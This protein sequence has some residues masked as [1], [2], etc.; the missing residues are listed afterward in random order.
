M[1]TV[2]DHRSTEAQIQKIL[3]DITRREFIVGG[4]AL[5][6]LL[7]GCA[8]DDSDELGDSPST[9]GPW[10]FTDDR[11]V[12][13]TL[14]TMP[15]RIAMFSEAAGALWEYGI[16]PVGVFGY[17]PM[18]AE[19]ALAK[20]DLTG[21]VELG[22][23][24]GEIPLEPLAALDADLIVTIVNSLH[25]N[26]PATPDTG[27]HTFSGTQ[28]MSKVNE[29][30][31]ILTIQA[32]VDA[33]TALGRMEEL[34]QA[35][36]ADT[37]SAEVVAAKERFAESSEALRVVAADKPDVRV[38]GFSMYDQIYIGRVDQLTDLDYFSQLGVDMVGSEGKESFQGFSFEQADAI[39]ADVVIFDDRA[40]TVPMD[41]VLAMPTIEALPAIKAGQYGPWDQSALL[42][43]GNWAENLD[44]LAELLSQAEVVAPQS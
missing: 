2:L 35:L 11:G 7:V 12:E 1:P 25:F 30:V 18:E 29:I 41:D 23:A 14:P 28:Q 32:N 24:Y 31:P 6:G 17:G 37:E 10:S 8:P 20:V 5:A 4:A 43:Y 33:S 16:K 9:A 19:P 22:A 34:A 42:S 36:G 38:I 26:E 13:I 40:D 44:S 15:T 3:D 27:A 39:P 21:V